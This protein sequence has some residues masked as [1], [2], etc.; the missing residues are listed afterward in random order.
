MQRIS[1]GDIINVINNETLL[2]S[3]A[4]KIISKADINPSFKVTKANHYELAELIYLNSSSKDKRVL[5]SIEQIKASVAN[6]SI[7][8][9]HKLPTLPKPTTKVYKA[10]RFIS[11]QKDG[12]AYSDI[13]RFICELKGIDFDHRT[14]ESWSGKMVR[15]NRGYYSTNIARWSKVYLTKKNKRYFL[16]E[17]ILSQMNVQPQ[18]D[19]LKAPVVAKSV[20]PLKPQVDEIAVELTRLMAIDSTHATNLASLNSE[21][22]DLKLKLQML[23]TS[24]ALNKE[25][26]K[27]VLVHSGTFTQD[28][29]HDFIY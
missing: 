15:T 18:M 22:N 2:S 27:K 6:G 23:N 9:S 14:L 28:S 11:E 25:K 10:L 17:E 19:N 3:P 1:K 5:W 16:R 8:I 24:R 4:V 13:Q 21:M 26:I 20:E 7:V 12:A 29:T